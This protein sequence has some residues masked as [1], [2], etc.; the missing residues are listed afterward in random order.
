MRWNAFRTVLAVTLSLCFLAE[1]S[2][3]FP[4]GLFLFQGTTCESG[5]FVA[6]FGDSETGACV[7]GN[8][9]V[10]VQHPRATSARFSKSVGSNY[11]I[12]ADC[13]TNNVSDC[14][15]VCVYS[16]TAPIG[17]CVTIPAST[18]SI[19]LLPIENIMINMTSYRQSTN[20]T[21]Y[22]GD[23]LA[24]NGI[25]QLS[26][27]CVSRSNAIGTPYENTNRYMLTNV[28]GSQVLYG[29]SCISADPSGYCSC[30]QVGVTAYDQCVTSDPVADRILILGQQVS[31][32]PPPS[33][34]ST[35]PPS[36]GSSATP[37]GGSSATPSGGSSAAP[38]GSGSTGNVIY[39]GIQL[40]LGVLALCFGN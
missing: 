9:T 35:I 33:I 20:C 11:S 38:T 23:V 3:S 27:K 5:T 12:G 4:I 25:P 2:R 17:S 34:T 6:Y 13:S 22:Y 36:G 8:A 19:L 40:A 16:A 31:L 24:D 30:T 18:I 39:P 26:G 14:H 21:D 7:Q 10:D 28:N 29:L 1:Q 37:A 15:G 32:P